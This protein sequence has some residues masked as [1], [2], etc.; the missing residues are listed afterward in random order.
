MFSGWTRTLHEISI[1]HNPTSPS[2][3]K[4][5]DTLRSALSSP[6]PPKL[7]S[8]PLNFDLEVIEAAPTADQ[9]KTILSFL[10]SKSNST[11]SA[12]SVF[13][14]A[15]SSDSASLDS[16]AKLGRDEPSA[17]KWPVVVDWNAGRAVVGDGA[18]VIEILDQLR[19]K[20]NEK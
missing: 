19:K 4:A 7:G 13:L 17:F 5:L 11:P 1:F 14:S 12:A 18:G 10:P 3:L 16:I 8:A 20:D 6:Y 15:G 9:L 2:S